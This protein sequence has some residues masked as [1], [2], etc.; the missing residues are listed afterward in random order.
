MI[1]EALASLL[2][3]ESEF[4]KSTDDLCWRIS[5]PNS[6]PSAHS[7]VRKFPASIRRKLHAD[8]ILG[9]IRP[10]GDGQSATSAFP[11]LMALLE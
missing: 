9:E 4:R 6:R 5:P 11:V 8:G 10:V 1:S 2:A 7:S 3:R